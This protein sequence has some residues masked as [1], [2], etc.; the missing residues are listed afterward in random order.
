MKIV[1][2]DDS[3]T[4]RAIIKGLFVSKGYEGETAAD[5]LEGYFKIHEVHPDAV[6][7]DVV[8]PGLNGY[9][10]CRLVK[11]DPSLSQIPVVLMTGSSESLDRFWGRYSGADIYI[12]K[13]SKG[14]I[15]LLESKITEIEKDLKTTEKRSC[16]DGKLTF[17]ETLD[18]LL[19]KTTLESEIRKLFN[20]IEDMD[21]TVQKMITFVRNLLELDS[22]SFLVLSVDESVFYTPVSDFKKI[23]DL[24]FSKLNRPSYPL[25]RRY[26]GIDG[27]DGIDGLMGTTRVISFDSREYGVFSVWRKKKFTSREEDAFS[28]ISEEFGGILKIGVQFALYRHNAN[29]DDLTGLFNF[30]SLEEKLATLW[31]DSGHFSFAMMDIDHFKRIN[32]KYGH[33]VGNEVLSEM[34]RIIR[35]LSIENGIFAARFG[36]EE[37]ALISE[38]KKFFWKRLKR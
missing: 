27:A 36:G 29:I 16:S 1:V 21:Y 6:V 34:G 37:F 5:G 20:H 9:R 3:N 17:A 28:I 12:Q 13:D 14:G 33:A 31:K 7:S 19:V 11:N 8:M 26:V 32:D 4:W 10:L 15:E 2:V 35:E 22:V 25:K 18:R 30:R 23:E 24:M 38:N